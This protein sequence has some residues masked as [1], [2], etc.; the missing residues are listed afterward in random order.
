MQ[1]MQHEASGRQALLASSLHGEVDRDKGGE[2]ER[3]RRGL[4]YQTKAVSGVGCTSHRE[5]H[6][7]LYLSHSSVTTSQ[8]CGAFSC[9][10]LYLYSVP[11]FC[12]FIRAGRYTP[13]FC[14]YVKKKAYTTLYSSPVVLS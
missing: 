8:A 7:F 13:R 2:R 4:A 11:L 6:R 9:T 3:E 12:L 14:R 5:D 10:D 1:P